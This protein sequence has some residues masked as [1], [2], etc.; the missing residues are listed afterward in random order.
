MEGSGSLLDLDS[1]KEAEKTKKGGSQENGR[2]ALAN[3]ACYAGLDARY[4][5]EQ[6]VAAVLLQKFVNIHDVEDLTDHLENKKVFQIA[7]VEKTVSV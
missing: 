1:I 5:D 4:G 3:V 7:A 6:F 2:V